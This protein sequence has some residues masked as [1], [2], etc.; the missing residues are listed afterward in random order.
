[1]S[2][3]LKIG[4]SGGTFDPIHHG[5][6]IIS[7]IARDTFNLDKVLFIPTG[8]P[9]HKTNSVIADSN[10]RYE[11]VK[12]AVGSN[13]YFEAS[14]IEIERKGNT[15]TIDT[16]LELRKQYGENIDFY[17]IVGADT[18]NEI[19]TWKEF[20]KVCGLCEFIAFKRPGS[21]IIQ[22]EHVGEQL[23]KNYGAKIHFTDAP[24]VEISSTDIRQR[25]QSGRSI[26]YL[27]PEYVEEY[28]DIKKLYTK[29][30]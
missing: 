27:V 24:M 6:L 7:E 5:H 12:R 30:N 14:C 28:I 23:R 16:L 10:D 15:Y 13:P 2:G 21:D 26:K 25:V 18:V 19:V 9:P 29:K 4:I 17:F 3:N 8:T 22:Y 1:M 20:E 11:M